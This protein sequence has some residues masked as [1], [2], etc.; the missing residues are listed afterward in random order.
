VPL[1]LPAAG[2]AR[3]DSGSLEVVLVE[4]APEG[5]VSAEILR[6]TK[7][8]SLRMTSQTGMGVIKR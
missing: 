3:G 8:V 1:V 2:A 5:A 7:N 6:E 4:G